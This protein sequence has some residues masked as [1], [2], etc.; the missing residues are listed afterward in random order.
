MEQSSPL[1]SKKR[2]ITGGG[3][4]LVTG[5]DD[6]ANV[7]LSDEVE[8]ESDDEDDEMMNHLHPSSSGLMT[9]HQQQQAG[10]RFQ[11]HLQDSQQQYIIRPL[12]NNQL[13]KL[14]RTSLLSSCRSM[15]FCYADERYIFP[16][17]Y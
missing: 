9:G 2:R 8:K 12:V 4:N 11:K 17:S 7:L 10:V 1:K 16:L 14:S 15:E 6:P 13:S 3:Y 5:F